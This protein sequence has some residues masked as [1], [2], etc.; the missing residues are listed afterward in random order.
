MQ[1]GIPTPSKAAPHTARPGTSATAARTR[2]IR[3]TWPTAYCG[4][5]P[6]HRV[7]RLSTGSAVDAEQR[8]QL[9]ADERDQVGVVESQR[10]SSPI[11]PTEARSTVTSPASSG[12]FCVE[13]VTAFVAS[14]S[15]APTS[16]PLP[17]GGVTPA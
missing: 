4:S 17:A 16:S 5:P 8:P 1:A 9:A 2:A 7:T 14:R 12:H 13:R 15:P 6:P 11:R 10:P 3:S